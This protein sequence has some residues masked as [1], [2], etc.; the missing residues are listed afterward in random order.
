MK[1]CQ[2]SYSRKSKECKDER[3]EERARRRGGRE[4]GRVGRLAAVQ[5]S[6]WWW[7]GG[8]SGAPRFPLRG[9]TKES[10]MHT[11]RDEYAARVKRGEQSKRELEN[12]K[13]KRNPAAVQNSGNTEKNDLWSR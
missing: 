7:W 5:Q 8:A 2:N 13:S 11:K 12:A 9:G 3:T 10:T 1:I 6:G 4:G